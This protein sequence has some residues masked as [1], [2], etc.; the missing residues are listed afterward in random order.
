MSWSRG[1]FL[2]HHW[3]QAGNQFGSFEGTNWHVKG[4]IHTGSEIIAY[5]FTNYLGT[6][7]II[8]E[9]THKYSIYLAFAKLNRRNNASL[10]GVGMRI[11]V[12]LIWRSRTPM[13]LG[14]LLLQY[15]CTS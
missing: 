3:H 7:N 9:R 1:R 10:I 6:L 15:P 8:T 11:L 13:I 12:S 4:L 14:H 5:A 2:F